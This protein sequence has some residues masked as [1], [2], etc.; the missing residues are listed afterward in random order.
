MIQDDGPVAVFA[1]GMQQY[2]V[3]AE[4]S[5]FVTEPTIIWD[6]PAAERGEITQTRSSYK[7]R[8]GR[9]A[10]LL[11]TGKNAYSTMR[12]SDKDND[13]ENENIFRICLV[14]ATVILATSGAYYYI[15]TNDVR[16][17]SQEHVLMAFDLI[18]HELNARREARMPLLT[19]LSA[20]R[21]P[22]GSTCWTC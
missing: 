2:A 9:R 22:T 15:F 19:P 8:W 14:S 1:G 13:A 5:D 17:R 18:T 21:S 11:R 12:K 10:C 6:F 16:T 7:C 3:R 4:M 20:L